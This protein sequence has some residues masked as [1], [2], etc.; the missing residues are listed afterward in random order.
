MKKIDITVI[1]K[2]VIVIYTL[3]FQQGGK[4]DDL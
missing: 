1:S 4:D 2:L 3:N